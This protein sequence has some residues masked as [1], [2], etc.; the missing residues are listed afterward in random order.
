ML[1]SWIHIRCQTKL[2]DSGQTVYVW[3]LQEVIDELTGQCDEPE[4]GVV[5]YFALIQIFKFRS[6]E[7][8]S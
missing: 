2:F 7:V 6:L 4:D 1:R 3:V 5:D 8:E